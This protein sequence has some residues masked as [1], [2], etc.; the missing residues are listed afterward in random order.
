MIIRKDYRNDV[1]DFDNVDDAN[2]NDE[3]Y[4]SIA[5]L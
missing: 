5:Y 4:V 2:T 1:N 3:D